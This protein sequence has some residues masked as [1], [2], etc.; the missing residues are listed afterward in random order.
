MDLALCILDNENLKLEYSGANM[1][2]YIIRNGELQTIGSDR[3]PIGISTFMSTSF[4]RHTIDVNKGDI[5]YTF[6]DGFEDQFGGPH[7]KKFM[8]RNLRSLLSAIHSNPLQQQK[9][10]LQRT[11]TDWMGSNFQVDDI[12]V[13]GI[14]V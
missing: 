4:T 11:L 10:I 8:I 3:M 13:M 9:D 1:P 2:L 14:K 12:L 7:N 6:S 5:L